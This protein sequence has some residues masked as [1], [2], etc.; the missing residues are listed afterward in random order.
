M[1]ITELSIKKP[2]FAWM[3]MSA[4]IVFGAL[5]FNRLGISEKPDVD[6]PVVNIS[7]NWEG[8]A[9][10]VIELDVID[11]L[12]SSL[13]S[14]EGIKSM[15]SK[16]RR[17][18]ADVTLEFGLDKNVDIA[19]Q[20]VQSI[21]GQAQRRLPEDIEAPVVRKSNPEDRPILWL[22]LTS[23]KF[24][25]KELMV[26]VRDQIK[27]RFQTIEGVAEVIL[28]GYVDPALRVW[29]DQG[30]LNQY[31]LSVSDLV[32]AIGKEH[33][34]YPAGIFENPT[35]EFNIRTLGEASSP[36]DFSN[37]VIN[38]RGGAPNF[39]PIFLSKVATVEDNL[40]DQRRISRVMGNMSIGLGFRKQR[41]T[42]AVEV[43]KKVKAKM[44]EVIKILPE[45]A[46]MG[47]NYDG[48]VF[49][50]DSI[51]ELKF[52]LLLA[53]IMTSLVVWFFLGS[54]GAAFNI[55]LSIP[56]AIIA[57]FMALEFFGFT[58]NT[59][60]M[61]GLTLAVG[62]VVDDNIMV[63]ENITRLHKS[64][65]NKIKASL[66]GTKEITFAALASS[67]AIIAIFLPLGFVSGLVGRYFYEF[68]IT[69]CAAICFSYID[70]ITLTP[71][72]TSFLL[73]KDLNEGK[74]F[75]DKVLDKLEE[76][77]KRT[78][79]WC[80]DHR[81]I[82]LSS[83]L[84][85][86]LGSGL[87]IKSLDREFTPAQDQSRL[88]LFIKTKAGSSL[89]FTEKKVALVE[90]ILMEQSELKRY[91]V[92]I[93]G[94]SGVESNTAFS[95]VTMHPID[96]RAKNK[97][98]N[99]VLSQQEFANFLRGEFKEKVKGAFIFI[100]DPSLGGFGTGSSYP[101]E[102]SLAGA[103][104]ED[105]ITESERVEKMMTDSGLMVE[106]DSDYQGKIPEL[107]IIP[108]REK[109]KLMGVS[110]DDIGRTIQ[111]MISGITAGKFSK[112][113]RRYDIV[114]KI[115]D[116]DLQEIKDISAIKVRN[117]RGELIA[118]SEVTKIV[119]DKGLLS[120]NR[121]DR[122]RAITMT[123]NLA[124]DVGQG[125]ALDYLRNTI[126]PSLKA[127][128]SLVESGSVQTYNESFDSLYYVIIL[129]LIIAYM[130]LASQFNSFLHP[131]T[132]LSVLPFSF[133]GAFITLKLAD[134]SINIYSMIGLILL[135]GIVKKNSI[136]LVDFTNQIRE[137]G[138]DV[139]DAL[140]QACPIRLRPIIMTSIS[141]IAGTLP[142]ALALG[143]GAETRVPMALSVIG[144]L[145]LA[146][147]LTLFI[148]PCVLFTHTWKN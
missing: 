42:N 147:V 1:S 131:I 146:T 26:Y 93:G 47:V 71:M 94:F 105:L 74:R 29:V 118:L 113:G 86:T 119:E 49:I 110:V 39:N 18:R 123:S 7:V 104:Y 140:M 43:A 142:A 34:E 58:L 2:V 98:L 65:M 19:V 132:I 35:T 31:D 115:K 117:N 59:F 79:N 15:S 3:L 138:K 32:N 67:L 88:I 128:V 50:E 14:V 134:Q 85:I 121:K 23:S 137:E 30:K 78:L 143:P 51:E 64:G 44:Q 83:A 40:E 46:E 99:K 13:L 33:A 82:V 69:I 36:E 16:A 27:D 72:R 25:K 130:V 6:N 101:I 55:M 124:A 133:T 68:A 139:R 111:S 62:L 96:K 127:G 77:Y 102:F 91:F 22:S 8:A 73:G 122:S 89:E 24:S 112:G 81:L 60:T 90:K 141:T 9:P 5:S 12:E 54:F 61:L 136:I 87:I 17:G 63:L 116:Q 10:E 75:I 148:V 37:I 108:D 57:T 4:F 76:K 126:K 106:V 52:T 125:V 20:E 107:R 56:T 145:A 80:L 66:L 53:G 144:G 129:G 120:I 95:Y 21:L 41:G 70:A 135:M 38:Q 45:G 28:G 92:A 100:R 84:L 114:V 48:T 11:Q 109:A 103:N 97:K